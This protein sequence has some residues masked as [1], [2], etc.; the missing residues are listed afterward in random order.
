MKRNDKKRNLTPLQPNR[1]KT[2]SLHIPK[3]KKTMN[4]P[5]SHPVFTLSLGLLSPPPNPSFSGIRKVRK[6][7]KISV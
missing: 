6:F 4:K 3:E 1:L 5:Q 7:Y 2:M